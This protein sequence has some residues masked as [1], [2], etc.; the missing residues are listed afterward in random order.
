[1]STIQLSLTYE[2]IRKIFPVHYKCFDNTKNHCV[3]VQKM[4]KINKCEEEKEN[5]V[6]IPDTSCHHFPFDNRHVPNNSRVSV[7]F[8]S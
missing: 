7:S 6:C 4:A 1:M 3:V 8:L 5:F 2:E